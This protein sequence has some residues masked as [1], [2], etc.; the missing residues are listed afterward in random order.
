[1]NQMHTRHRPAYEAG[2]EDYANEV[3]SGVIEKSRTQTQVRA[4]V[5]PPCPVTLFP[6]PPPE[7]IASGIRQALCN[8]QPLRAVFLIFV[9]ERN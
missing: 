3:R 5:Y 7:Y 9:Y 1:M 2:R 8:P 4:L 6:S